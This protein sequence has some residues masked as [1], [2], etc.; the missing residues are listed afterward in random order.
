MEHTQ[1]QMTR[2]FC[3]NYG[4]K[5]LLLGVFKCVNQLPLQAA[6]G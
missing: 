4:N 5:R 1:P 3:L 2:D 6:D